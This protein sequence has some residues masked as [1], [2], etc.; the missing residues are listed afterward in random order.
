MRTARARRDSRRTRSRTTSA[1]VRRVRSRSCPRLDPG[2]FNRRNHE[3][4]VRG[5]R[6]IEPVTD[7][8]DQLLKRKQ[9]DQYAGQRDYHIERGDRR[10]RRQA[11]AAKAPEVVEIAEPDQARGH[12]EHDK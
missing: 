5:L 6:M 2:A 10:A 9:R 1:P 12:A 3:I 11:E 7:A 8:V 4:L